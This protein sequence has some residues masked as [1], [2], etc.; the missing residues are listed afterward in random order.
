MPRSNAKAWSASRPWTRSVASSAKP[1]RAVE[2]AR[3]WD[4]NARQ[5]ARRRSWRRRSQRPPWTTALRTT[6]PPRPYRLRPRARGRP[7]HNRRDRHSAGGRLPRDGDRAEGR[8]SGGK[9]AERKQADRGATDTDRAD[10]QAANRNRRDRDASYREDRTDGNVT[11]CNPPTRRSGLSWPDLEINIRSIQRQPRE[12]DRRLATFGSRRLEPTF[13]QGRGI[14]D[15]LGPCSART[16]AIS[17]CSAPRFGD[18][19]Q[20]SAVEIMR[21]RRRTRAKCG[22]AQTKVDDRQQERDHGKDE[23]DGAGEGLAIMPALALTAR[24]NRRPSS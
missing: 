18:A 6:P 15:V 21:S 4:D 11:D 8:P 16:R 19:L 24:S 7:R 1:R 14:G 20:Q 23:R 3:D 5:S 10:S 2:D 9:A 12:L 13:R 22:C 17:R